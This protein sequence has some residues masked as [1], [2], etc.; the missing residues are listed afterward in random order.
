MSSRPTPSPTPTATTAVVTGAAG[1]AAAGD[2]AS[3]NPLVLVLDLLEEIGDADLMRAA[4]VDP[5]LDR[6]T[7]VVGVHV[8]VPDSV[9]ADDHDRV[10]E[11]A[12]RVLERGRSMCRA[13]RGGT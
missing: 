9:A 7:D 3:R 6:A 12:P 11:R 13:R 8:A 4:G 5:R 1:T 10:A 2:R